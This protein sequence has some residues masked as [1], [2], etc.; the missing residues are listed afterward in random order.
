MKME[1]NKISDQNLCD[2]FFVVTIFATYI[3]LRTMRLKKSQILCLCYCA[4]FVVDT[5]VNDVCIIIYLLVAKLQ[6]I[7]NDYLS[8]A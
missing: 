7:F 1:Q 5:T 8:P 4:Y 6:T 2:S 3:T